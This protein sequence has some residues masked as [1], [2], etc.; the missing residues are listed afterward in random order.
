VIIIFLISVWA[1]H[2]AMATS[3]SNEE[4]ITLSLESS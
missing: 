3:D 4:S 2:G 1:L